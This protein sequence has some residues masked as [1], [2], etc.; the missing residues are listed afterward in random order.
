MNKKM[1]YRQ[2][3]KQHTKVKKENEAL[4]REIKYIAALFYVEKPDHELFMENKLD[5]D[6]LE[7]IKKISK[8]FNKG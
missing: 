7:T 2:L 3:L 1:S 8:T 4:I 5:G 6:F